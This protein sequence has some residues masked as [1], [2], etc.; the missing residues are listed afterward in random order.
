MEA[1]P[2][3][4]GHEGAGVVEAVG[5]G[6]RGVA[7]GD[8][9]VCA[10]HP[11]VVDRCRW[12]STGRAEPV[13]PW[14]RRSSR[15]A[16]GRT[17]ASRVHVQRRGGTGAMCMLGTFSSHTVVHED[18]VVKIDQDIPLEVAVLCGCGVP[19]GW[20]SAVNTGNTQIGDTVL[21]F[22]IGGIG[23]ERGAGSVASPG[24]TRITAVDPLAQ[25]PRVRAGEFGATHIVRQPPRRRSGWQSRYDAGGTMAESA[26]VT[27]DVG[28]RAGSCRP[29][30][31]RSS[32]RTARLVVTGLAHPMALTVHLSGMPIIEV[33]A[34]AADQGLPL[35]P[36]QPAIGHP[37]APV[38][39]SRRQADAGRASDAH[40]H[41][42]GD[43]RG[44]RRSAEPPAR[45]SAGVILHEH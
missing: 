26:L 1:L 19:T 24:A 7:E 38:D 35:R 14:A 23:A 3:I 18:S 21:V 39:V 28:Q 27:V 45:T 17:A 33:N 13:R 15:A 29:R 4:G 37:E 12:C 25:Q 42:G 20:G 32:G 44:L 5:P 43:Q 31:C 41:A 36:R 11:G 6:V 30:R 40:V 34:K 2:T 10:L 8:H 16:C 22:G 9:V